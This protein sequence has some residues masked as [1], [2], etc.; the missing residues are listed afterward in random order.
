MR[1][2]RVILLVLLLGLA[3]PSAAGSQPMEYASVGISPSYQEAAP[4]AQLAFTVTGNSTL[5]GT[6]SVSVESGLTLEGDPLCS[7]SCQGPFVTSGGCDHYRS[8]SRRTGCN[9]RLHCC[10]ESCGN[11]R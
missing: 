7:G 1:I 3:M 11:H 6:V 2:Y 4:G 5:G 10:R 8:N 9:L